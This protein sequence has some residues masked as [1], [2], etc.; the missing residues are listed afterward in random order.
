MVALCSPSPSTP[1]T[2]ATYFPPAGSPASSK[3]ALKRRAAAYLLLLSGRRPVGF[4][5][6]HGLLLTEGLDGLHT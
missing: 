2:E 6:G 3:L 5:V 1:K 4:K